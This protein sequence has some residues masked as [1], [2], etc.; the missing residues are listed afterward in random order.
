MPVAILSLAQSHAHTNV[1]HVPSCRKD[2][3]LS[4]SLGPA[5]SEQLQGGI[6]H[7]FVHRGAAAGS[8][9]GGV[10]SRQDIPAR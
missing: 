9:Q 8:L 10:E 5:F 3:P 2:A 4:S 1:S 6:L 7:G